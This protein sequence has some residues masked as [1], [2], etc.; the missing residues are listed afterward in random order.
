MAE[1]GNAD[2][3]VAGAW[4]AGSDKPEKQT[5]RLGFIPLV[6]GAT[7]AM[8]AELG[9]DKRYGLRIETRKQASWAM[10]R[11]GLGD[12]TLDASHALYSMVYGTHLGI[13]GD[14]TPMAILMALSQNGQGIVLARSIAERGIRDGWALAQAVRAGESLT[15]AH[16]F[17]TGT[18]AMWLA[19]WLAAHG[20]DPTRDVDRVVVPPPRTV[21][22]LQDGLVH[23]F[24]VGEPWH[25]VAIETGAG[26]NVATTQSMWPGHP[27]KVLAATAQWVDA[28]PN[29]A[30]ALTAA[31][32]DT[33]RYVDDPA[34]R[35]AVARRLAQPDLIGQPAD[36]IAGCLAGHGRDGLGR[37]WQDKDG[38]TFFDAGRATYPYPSDGMWFLTQFVR[39]G[40]LREAPDYRA[41]ASEVQRTA[42]YAQAAAAAGVPV[43]PS[44]DRDVRLFDGR[45]WRARDAASYATSF[46][47]AARRDA[48]QA[49]DAGA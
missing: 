4:L 47:I 30:R 7:V 5:V 6:D 26:F 31:L 10:V 46:P 15:L 28:H 39:W 24:C 33:A 12:G 27:E 20:I 35:E 17:A 49:A 18:H 9:F 11:D 16:T 2:S 37:Q 22:A 13:G 43:P 3:R 23:G 44:T 36:L 19:Y 29:T 32:L 34:N 42:L 40:L 38:L 48:T 41:V 45:H 21:A 25:T 1:G 14:A 8:A